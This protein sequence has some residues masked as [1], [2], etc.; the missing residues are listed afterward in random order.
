MRKADSSDDDGSSEKQPENLASS[1]KTN[2][3]FQRSPRNLPIRQRSLSFSAPVSRQSYSSIPSSPAT[4]FLSQFAARDD[5][6]EAPELSEGSVVQNYVLGRLIGKGG[7]SECREAYSLNS[8]EITLPSNR[9]ALK[10]VTDPRCMKSFQREISIWSKLRHENILPLYNHFSGSGFHIAVTILASKGN[11]QELIVKDGPLS[12]ESAKNLFEQ[13]CNAVK[14]LHDCAEVVHLDLKLENVVLD[15]SGRI[16]LCDFGL[17][18]QKHSLRSIDDAIEEELGFCCG[19]V[20]SL[21]PE[22]LSDELA[23]FTNLVQFDAL[24]KQDIWALGVILYSLVTGQVPFFD[25]YLPRLQQSIIEARYSPL[26]TNLSKTLESLI[27]QLLQRVPD[28]RPDICA[29]CRHE[30]FT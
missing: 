23:A 20:A 17:S 27:K 3:P 21:P 11:L 26:P 15:D 16:Y 14:Y 22:A 4:N 8:T 18:R 30:W 9:I 29:I 10:I 13:I 25:E 6:F 19:S 5:A 12:E 24:K 7:S 2:S 28:H 1:T